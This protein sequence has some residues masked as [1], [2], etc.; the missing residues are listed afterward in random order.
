MAAGT[1]Q[2]NKTEGIEPSANFDQ[3]IL[4]VI[5]LDTSR[6]LVDSKSG[7]VSIFHR[8]RLSSR[9]SGNGTVTGKLSRLLERQKFK[10]QEQSRAQ[11]PHDKQGE[12]FNVQTG[13]NKVQDL[14]KIY[15]L[16]SRMTRLNKSMNGHKNSHQN[17]LSE[18]PSFR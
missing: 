2:T 5:D 3:G 9:G 10:Q 13:H 17:A 12:L 15:R 1:Q 8:A 16:A 4:E 6:Q 14:G 18:K 7:K 11:A